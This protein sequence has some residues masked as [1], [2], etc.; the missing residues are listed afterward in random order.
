M[1]WNNERRALCVSV[2]RLGLRLRISVSQDAAGGLVLEHPH[3]A[4][5]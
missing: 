4:A 3:C 2:P 5:T 1:L